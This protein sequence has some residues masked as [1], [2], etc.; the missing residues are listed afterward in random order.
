MAANLV[1]KVQEASLHI[2]AAFDIGFEI[3]MSQIPVLF[4]SHQRDTVG[5][6]FFNRSIGRETLPIRI[7]FDT[8]DIDLQGR[9]QRCQVFGTFFDL[10]GLSLELICPLTASFEDFPRIAAEIQSSKELLAV[11]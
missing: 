5:Y 10:G 4:G 3:R 9:M 6:N 1:Y 2:L 8:V 7:G 11:M